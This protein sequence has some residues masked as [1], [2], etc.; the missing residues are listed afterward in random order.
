MKLI[1]IKLNK[2]DSLAVF[3]FLAV[4]F[5]MTNCKKEPSNL[6]SKIL[7]SV[8]FSDE[9]ILDTARANLDWYLDAIE[10]GGV[11]NYG[12][13]STSEFDLIELGE[14]YLELILNQDF[15][16]D[17]K[18][19]NI[20]NYIYNY[21]SWRIPLEVNNEYRCYIKISL[22]NDIL[23]LVSGGGSIFARLLDNC[24]RE[25]DLKNKEKEYLLFLRN[26]YNCNFLMVEDKKNYKIYPI[27]DPESFFL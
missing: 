9:E 5:I 11:E 7:E 16:E 1:L 4:I 23:S 22:H 2:L 21:N 10:Y 15:I 12:F 24:E 27:G 17:D 25:Y 14:P 20:D 26:D 18:F 13:H 6:D 19:S 3:L 8:V